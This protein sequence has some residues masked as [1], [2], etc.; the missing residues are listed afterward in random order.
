MST[1]VNLQK[2]F[3]QQIL[4]SLEV[5]MECLGV[6][7]SPEELEELDEKIKKKE[8]DRLMDMSVLKAMA[9]EEKKGKSSCSASTFWTGGFGRDGFARLAW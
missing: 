8:I 7:L 9:P 6:E 2:S 5:M 3:Q 4:V 1:F